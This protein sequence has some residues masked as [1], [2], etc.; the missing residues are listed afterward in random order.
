[1]HNLAL[2]DLSSYQGAALYSWNDALF[3][4][5]DWE[6]I[7][8]IGRSVKAKTALKVGRFGLGFVSVYHLTGES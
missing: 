7:Q 1:M 3:S 2:P 8:K 5:N 4:E 6:G